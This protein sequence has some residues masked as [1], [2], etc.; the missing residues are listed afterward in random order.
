VTAG[1]GDLI[2]YGVSACLQVDGMEVEV[3]GRGPDMEM[4][5]ASAMAVLSA[6]GSAV[7]AQP[8]G[9]PIPVGATRASKLG[10][11]W[12]DKR[13]APAARTRQFTS[14]QGMSPRC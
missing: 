2:R 13:G 8:D 3:I 12:S 10:T 4:S 1:P 11:S 14:C 6:H 9:D 7:L 5:A